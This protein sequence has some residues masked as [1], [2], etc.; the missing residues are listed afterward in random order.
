MVSVVVDMVDRVN[1]AGARLT[2]SGGAALTVNGAVA[3][4]EAVVI[5]TVR[6]PVAAAAAM[7]KFAD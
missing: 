6:M 3:E 1:G 2:E 5:V 4:P 7:T